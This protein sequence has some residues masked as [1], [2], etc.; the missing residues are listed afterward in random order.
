MFR[1]LFYMLLLV[2]FLAAGALSAYLLWGHYLAWLGC[3]DAYGRCFDAS[4][5][6]NLP[7]TGIPMAYAAITFVLSLLTLWALVGVLRP[8]RPRPA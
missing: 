5:A 2:A 7:A 4:G 1:R 6:Q 3:T 8:R